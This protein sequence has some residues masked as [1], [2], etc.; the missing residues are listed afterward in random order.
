MLSEFQWVKI[1]VSMHQVDCLFKFWIIYEI[2]VITFKSFWLDHKK[3][4]KGP[5]F[6]ASAFLP[7]IP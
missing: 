4:A 1:L 7:L 5:I 3:A 6:R 2:D